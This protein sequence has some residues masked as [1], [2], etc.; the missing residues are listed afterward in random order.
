MQT[1]LLL[2]GGCLLGVCNVKTVF[3]R[4][5]SVSEVITEAHVLSAIRFALGRLFGLLNA[6]T[7]TI[8]LSGFNGGMQS[9]N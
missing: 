4:L 5:H 2:L 9:F 7:L 3:Q 1:D 8:A 6:T